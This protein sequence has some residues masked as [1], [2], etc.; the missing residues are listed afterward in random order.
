MIQIEAQAL[1][2]LLLLRRQLAEPCAGL[3]LRLEGDACQGWRVTLEWG[4]AQ[5]ED[6][7]R[8][9][10]QGLALLA[11]IAHWPYL[12]GATLTAGARDQ[13]Q[14]IWIEIKAPACHCDNQACPS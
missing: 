1:Q 2:H 11:A 14:G 8:V 9:D 5:R 6:E 13:D 4:A 3:R 7:Y 10:Y 12:Q